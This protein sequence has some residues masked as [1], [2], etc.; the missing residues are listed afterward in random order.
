MKTRKTCA[1]VIT[2]AMSLNMLTA[3]GDSSDKYNGRASEMKAVSTKNNDL[4]SSETDGLMPESTEKNAESSIYSPEQNFTI[5]GDVSFDAVVSQCSDCEQAL[6]YHISLMMA[7]NHI[8]NGDANSATYREKA[9]EFQQIIYQDMHHSCTAETLYVEDMPYYVGEYSGLYTGSW[10][11]AG[12]AGK[13]SFFGLR[14]R[15]GTRLSAGGNT[16]TYTGDWAYGLP[17]GYGDSYEQI[18]FGG[19]ETYYSGEF[20][21]GERS[22]WGVM[23]QRV[24]DRDRFYGE[25]SWSGGELVSETDV[26]EYTVSTGEL[27]AIGKMMGADGYAGWTEYQTAEQIKSKLQSA[28]L[29]ASVVAGGVLGYMYADKTAPQIGTSPE[30]QMAALATWRADKEAADKMDAELYEEKQEQ[31]RENAKYNYEKLHENDP[32][33]YNLDT[34]KWKN[35]M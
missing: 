23:Y 27:Y 17:E 4:S 3:C 21:A 19:N 29:V 24:G 33:D 9:K 28:L 30:E 15:D 26:A 18:G 35:R 34:I 5:Q 7:F 14:H 10:K 22:G 16:F 2:F 32:N 11:G 12:P 6:T 25:A 8:D 31:M 13:G 20:E 1:L